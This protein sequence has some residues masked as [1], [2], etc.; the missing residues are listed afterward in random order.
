MQGL[1]CLKGGIEREKLLREKG[2]EK[3]G[4]RCCGCHGWKSF[5]VLWPLGQSL[6]F[7]AKKTKKKLQKL[8]Y[9]VLSFKEEENLE[10][11]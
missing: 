10:K 3:L 8:I 7:M 1:S 9:F 11:E 4:R 6:I 5:G 2:E